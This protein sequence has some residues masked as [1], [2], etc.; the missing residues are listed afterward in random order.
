MHYTRFPAWF[1]G[2]HQKHCSLQK[3]FSLANMIYA[4][5]ASPSAA[6]VSPQNLA[7]AAA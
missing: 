6:E 1:L 7:F 2:P 4:T 3:P 5:P